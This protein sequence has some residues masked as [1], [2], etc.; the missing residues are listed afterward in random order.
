MPR[1]KVCTSSPLGCG[2]QKKQ[3]FR[4]KS[5]HLRRVQKAVSSDASDVGHPYWDESAGIRF[6][7]MSLMDRRLD[8]L[9]HNAPIGVAEQ[10]EVGGGLTVE[11]TDCCVVRDQASEGFGETAGC[12]DRDLR[13][14]RRRKHVELTSRV[15]GGREGI[16]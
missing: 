1:S 4:A 7:I 10:V 2:G 13:V 11:L 5:L 14:S 3:P 16:G 15:Q 12:V 9:V 8:A 6:P